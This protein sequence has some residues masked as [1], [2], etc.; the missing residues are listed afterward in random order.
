MNKRNKK[1]KPNQMSA[2]GIFPA[3]VNLNLRGNIFLGSGFIWAK[4]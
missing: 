2:S 3:E 4:E 1:K